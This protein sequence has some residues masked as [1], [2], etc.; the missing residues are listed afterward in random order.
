MYIRYALDPIAYHDNIFGDIEK[1]VQPRHVSLKS[2]DT[3]QARRN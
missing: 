2:A 3:A 1:S